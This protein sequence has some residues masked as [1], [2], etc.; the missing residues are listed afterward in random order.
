M[1]GYW[2][3]QE[4]GD[5]RDDGDSDVDAGFTEMPRGRAVVQKR[6]DVV[7]PFSPRSCCVVENGCDSRRRGEPMVGPDGKEITD[8]QIYVDLDALASKK[9]SGED[10]DGYDSQDEDLRFRTRRI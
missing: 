10:D 2:F 6:C 5:L 4:A 9:Q 8:D 3:E 7:S 1:S